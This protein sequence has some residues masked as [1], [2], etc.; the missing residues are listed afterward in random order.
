M[1]KKIIIKKKLNF[2]FLNYILQLYFEIR[3]YFEF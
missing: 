2:I 3:I 1:E